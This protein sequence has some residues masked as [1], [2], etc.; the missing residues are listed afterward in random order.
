MVRPGLGNGGCRIIPCQHKCLSERF[1]GKAVSGQCLPDST[2]EQ[3]FPLVDNPALVVIVNG[4]EQVFVVACPPDAASLQSHG[5]DGIRHGK[6]RTKGT[7]YKHGF[8]KETVVVVI[9]DFLRKTMRDGR[10]I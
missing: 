2:G 9:D 4:C 3:R 6:F 7:G 8:G 10:G 5:I 1:A